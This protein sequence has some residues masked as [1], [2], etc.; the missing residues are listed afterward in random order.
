MATAKKEYS[1]PDAKPVVLYGLTSS[2]STI[3]IPIIVSSSGALK[4][5][6]IPLDARFLKLDQTT[7]Q[8]TI[9]TFTFPTILGVGEG[10]IM[11]NQPYIT[12]AG[13]GLT[14]INGEYYQVG[15]INGKPQYFKDLH[16]IYWDGSNWKI[17]QNGTGTAYV[18][19]QDVATP[20]LIT[21][22]DIYISTPPAGTI[23]A[24]VDPQTVEEAYVAK[25]L[26]FS[27][28]DRQAMLL[29][30][31]TTPFNVT[32]NYS[33]MQGI[34]MNRARLGFEN[35]DFGTTVSAQFYNKGIYNK[36]NQ[37]G[38]TS[39]ISKPQVFNLSTIGWENEIYSTLN[40]AG[41]TQFGG[42]ESLMGMTNII[43]KTG[44]FQPSDDFAIGSNLNAVGLYNQIIMSP[45]ISSAK[46][47]SILTGIDNSVSGSVQLSVTP[48]YTITV[49]GSKNVVGV[50][51]GSSAYPIT[52]YGSYNATGQSG[53]TNYGT[54][55]QARTQNATVNYGV[56][57]SAELGT[58]NWA[59]YTGSG[60]NFFGDDNV[61][62]YFGTGVDASI[63]YDA[64]NL[65]INPREVGTG[66][67][68]VDYGQKISGVTLG[69]EKITNGTFTGSATGWTVPA[70]SSYNT[71]AIRKT[72]NGLD[73]LTQPIANM[74]TPLVLGELMTLTFVVSN[75]TSGG[76]IPSCGG[77][78]LTTRS[79]NGTYTE[80]F[81]VVDPTDPIKF[82]PSAT[83]SRYY[84]DT[85][86]LKATT[87]GDLTLD[88][89]LTVYHDALIYGDTEMKGTTYWTDGGL[90]FGD[91][92][93]SNN[94]TATTISVVDTW[95][96]ITVFDDDVA[97]NDTDVDH[98]ND[99]IVI[100]KTGSYYVSFTADCHGGTVN[101]SY[102]VAIYK[103]NGATL[104]TGLQT[105]IFFDFATSEPQI[106]LQGIANL[107]A[108]D[109]VEVWV[110]NTTGAND[111]TFNF[112]NITLFMLGA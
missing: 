50:A 33:T 105:H 112:A 29:D 36:I 99:H 93:A 4:I 71:N 67:L 102:E 82:T 1:S 92:N 16:W 43:S 111:V 55:S 2:A 98:T 11:K 80:T 41:T 74:V 9:G 63:Y 97:E 47:A 68:E 62:T 19:S 26:N 31:T 66:V 76:V 87:D 38:I 70:G 34:Y 78:T 8:T 109:T 57:A 25:R 100:N 108:G 48:A 45:S 51:L 85:I 107:T 22:W 56:W 91:M 58:T 14:I 5:D 81:R 39:F 84:L 60:N 88:G 110:K 23:V 46:V 13:F 65:V 101:N 32:E 69:S 21:S 28:T 24:D 73:P 52:R 90:P 6:P 18:S 72:A 12:V 96:Q 20:D 40:L 42:G 35:I 83:T 75:R 104:L 17:M 95:Y 15:S 59:F 53:G 89:D 44:T 3:A 86:S 94:A 10:L 106:S 61:K 103:N 7:P 79:A 30:G 64:T 54:W 77:V 49:Y 27:A 37:S